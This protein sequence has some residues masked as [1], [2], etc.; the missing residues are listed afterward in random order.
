MSEHRMPIPARAYNA[1]VGGHVCGPDDID[2]GQKVVHLIKYDRDGNEVSFESQVTKANK[3]YVIHD[4]FT[5]S[6]NVT[7]PANCV[8]EFDGGSINCS[9]YVITGNKMPTNVVYTPEQFGAG[10]TSDDTKAIQTAVNLCNYVKMDGIYNVY[11]NTNNFDNGSISV[12][13]NTTIYMNG[14]I[15]YKTD[16]LDTYSIFVLDEVSNVNIVGNGKYVGDKLFHVGS[17][18]EWGHGICIIHS[19]HIIINGG[20]FYNFWGDGIYCGH[21]KGANTQINISNVNIHDFRRQGI[22]ICSGSHIIIS[23]SN[24]SSN[25]SESYG[26]IQHSIDVETH[27]AL[28]PISNIT[29]KNTNVYNILVYGQQTLQNKFEH[30]RIENV[31]LNSALRAYDLFTNCIISNCIIP[32]LDLTYG[33]DT[34]T[35]GNISNFY[36]CIITLLCADSVA[37]F[38]NCQINGVITNYDIDRGNERIE[39]YNSILDLLGT[40]INTNGFRNSGNISFYFLGCKFINRNYI[41]VIYVRN[42]HFENCTLDF[43][44]N[45]CSKFEAKNCIIYARLEVD[46]TSDYVIYADDL[47]LYNCTIIITSEK[48]WPLY[49]LNRAV[50][51]VYNPL[52][53]EGSVVIDA[54]SGRTKTYG[55]NNTL[56]DVGTIY[57][58]N[59]VQQYTN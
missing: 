12:P 53:N 4:D 28:Y 43:Y 44:A 40:D 47:T 36:D 18:G 50:G 42:L 49:R 59:H 20:E 52:I 33:G 7:I 39:L 1:A 54:I 46:W 51:G 13:S 3:I 22:S 23:D 25:D 29:I 45:I 57:I 2:F 15:N 24:I 16:N 34:Y 21:A 19:D 5:L 11:A 58:G 31:N 37:K 41:D 30:I 27:N 6:S 32:R 38:Y 26:S 10:K 55:S 56:Y 35:T 14:T 17:T 8:L 9:N 48:T